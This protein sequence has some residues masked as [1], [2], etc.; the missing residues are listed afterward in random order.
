MSDQTHTAAGGTLS[1][2]RLLFF[3]DAV[4]AIAITLLVIELKAPELPPH[5]ST[6]A[7]VDALVAL[8]PN[9]FAFFLSFLVIGRFWVGHH[10]LFER[11]KGFSHRLY[12]PNLLLL[13]AIAFMPF[14]TAMLGA[15]L[16]AFLPT[17]LYN[18]MLL[19]IGLLNC[20]LIHRLERLELL[21][22][23]P[24]HHTRGAPAVVFAAAVCIALTFV[25]PQFSQMGML[26][27]PLWIRLG[28]KKRA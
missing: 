2:E 25:A 26:T 1:L 13:M 4:F 10:Q 28:R 24:A 6:Q 11:A 19:V 5:S 22:P 23:A 12:W 18:G 3:S 8:S 15:N 16:G 27:M 17:L 20:L 9:F 7:Y 21:A 14:V